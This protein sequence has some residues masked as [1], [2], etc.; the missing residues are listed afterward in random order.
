[1]HVRW[2]DHEAIVLERGH[3]RLVV[4]PSMGAR[5]VSLVDRRSD[6]E[7][8]VQGTPAAPGADWASDDAVFGGEEA[9]GWDE[10]LP[11]VSP[12]PDP[13]DP[14]GGLLRDHGDQ[15]GRDT[16]V[17]RDGDAVSATW[18]SSRWPYTFRRS[19]RIDGEAVVAD[20]E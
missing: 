15:W 6:R 20:Y 11:T 5:V 13:L 2:Q 8:L 1:M 12:C 9:F 7:W 17:T 19:L 10:C 4:V 18:A 16:E 14:G 3:V